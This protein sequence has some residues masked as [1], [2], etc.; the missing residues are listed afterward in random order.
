VNPTDEQRCKEMLALAEKA[1]PGPWEHDAKYPM[2][3]GERHA[4]VRPRGEALIIGLSG[5]ISY[6]S[7][8]KKKTYDERAAA[9]APFIA[10]ART[11][12]PAAAKEI[13]RLREALERIAN[14]QCGC[15]EKCRCAE[16]EARL[17]YAEEAQEVARA[18]LNPSAEDSDANRD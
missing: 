17:I 10:T 2:F 7:E 3:V 16:P 4:V 6:N 9:D 5:W 12:A 15:Q 13:M 14:P 11:F 18:A 8:T 1:T